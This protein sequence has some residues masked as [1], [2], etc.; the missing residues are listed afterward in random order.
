MD[1]CVKLGAKFKL[2]VLSI[3]LFILFSVFVVTSYCHAG[4]AFFFFFFFY[5]TL[6]YRITIQTSIVWS[7]IVHLFH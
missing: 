3:F 6:L 1:L 7:P 5:S 2:E 4:K